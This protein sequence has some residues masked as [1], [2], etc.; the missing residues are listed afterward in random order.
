[1]EQA[2]VP[3]KRRWLPCGGLISSPPENTSVRSTPRKRST[4]FS[5]KLSR[6]RSFLRGRIFVDNQAGDAVKSYNPACGGAAFQQIGD[7]E[8]VLVKCTEM[9]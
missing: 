1:M 4:A 9:Q 7:V 8:A 3:G 2:V 5:F 6:P